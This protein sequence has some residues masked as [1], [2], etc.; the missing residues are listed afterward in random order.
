MRYLPWQKV[1]LWLRPLPTPS[2]SVTRFSIDL[3]PG[4]RYTTQGRLGLAISA[5]GQ[6]IAYGVTTAGAR[7][8]YVRQ[9]DGFEASPLAGSE[10]GSGPFFSPD[11]KMVGFRGAVKVEIAPFSGGPVFKLA[12]AQGLTGA[13][14]GPDNTIVFAPDINTGIWRISADGGEPQKI[15]RLDLSRKESSHGWPQFLLGGKA[16]IFVIE[17]SGKS[18][19]EATIVAQMLESGQR[20]VLIEGGTFAHYLPTGHLLFA[21]S[22]A[23]YAVEFDPESLLVSGSLALPWAE[24]DSIDWTR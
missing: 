16:I 20:K 17:T 11:G 19:D 24:L 14:W 1:K 10:G 12:D 2:N 3:P 5:D 13:S 9:L 22:D 6:R 21:R 18:F 7:L 15:T 8:L 4:Q 23:L